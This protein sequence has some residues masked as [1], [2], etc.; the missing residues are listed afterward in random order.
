[1]KANARPSGPD[2][3]AAGAS[4]AAR[5]AV[6]PRRPGPG[7]PAG[8]EPHHIAVP[9]LRQRARRPA[10]R[11]QTNRGRHLPDAP[12]RAVGDQSDPEARSWSTPATGS[13]CAVRASCPRPWNGP[14]TTSRRLPALN[15][16]ITSSWSAKIRRRLDVHRGVDRAGLEDGAAEIAST[17]ASP[18]AWKGGAAGR[19]SSRRAMPGAGRHVRLAVQPGSRAWPASRARRRSGCHR[20]AG[21]RPAGAYGVA[22]PT[23]RL[24]WFT[25]P[26]P[27][28]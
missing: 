11:G 5:S 21:P 3:R 28:G 13:V 12:D 20:G 9:E 1:M 25:S 19:T 24:E 7:L 2:H 23:R 8:A 27:R 17:S 15:A 10:P 18:S 26:D 6:R 22:D 4:A 16:A 14:T